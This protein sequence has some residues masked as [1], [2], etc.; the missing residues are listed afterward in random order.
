MSANGGHEKGAGSSPARALAWAGALTAAVY[1]ATF[2][3]YV[4]GFQGYTRRAREVFIWLA[5]LPLLYLYWR[6][7]RVV[8]DSGGG[9]KTSTVVKFAALFCVL[10]AAVYPFHSTDVFGYVNRGWQQ[11]HYHMN[12]YVYT[13]AEVPGWR[14]DPMIWD[15]WIYNPNPYGF[16]FTL[17]ARGLTVLGG[18]N[19]ALTLA[20]FKAVNAAA[21][22]LTGWL[23]WSGAKRLDHGRPLLALYAFLWNPLVLLHHLA[24]GHNDI[25]IGCA[26]ALAAYFVVTQRDVWVLPALAAAVM[27]KYAPV[28]LVPAALVYVFKRRGWKVTALGCLLAALVVVAAVA[29][30]LADWRQFRLEDIRDNATLIDNSFH[31]FLIHIYENAARLFKPL[32]Q[33]HDAV[34]SGIK[35]VLRLFF[36]AFLVVIHW[37]FLKRSSAARLVELWA[38]VL[39]VLLCVVSSK[40]NG[41]YMGML[42]PPA[43][44][45]HERHWVRRATLLITSAQTLS[46]T[47]FKQAYILNY[48]AMILV[49]AGIVFRQVKRE[50]EQ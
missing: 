47:F 22:G 20:M 50:K 9:L 29:P 21:Y 2:L 7:Y 12:P 17:L 15:H 33:F 4:R 37:R 25:L 43:L 24:N 19:W 38:L 11:V 41:W 3:F 32:A 46:L 10:C 45:L 14:E 34:D 35:A 39:L 16:L 23:V 28:L 36:A 44:F 26:L 5:V 31:S 40:F 27:L 42:L 48:F 30:F 8:R 49:P 13:V 18:G 6:G 1:L